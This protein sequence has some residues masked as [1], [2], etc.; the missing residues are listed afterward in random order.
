MRLRLFVSALMLGSTEAHATRVTG[1]DVLAHW[2][3]T[4]IERL[5]GEQASLAGQD[6]IRQ[7]LKEP[8]SPY[9]DVVLQPDFTNGI[10][11]SATIDAFADRGLTSVDALAA[12][13]WDLGMTRARPGIDITARKGFR[14][15]Y[16][17]A[18]ASKAD[19][20]ADIFWHMLDLTGFRHSTKAAVYAVGM[21]ILRSQAIAV[22]SEQWI[23][24]GIDASVFARVM[25]AQHMD[26]LSHYDLEYLS[27]LVQYRLLHW[28]AGKA[29]SAGHRSLPVAYRVARAAAAY[30]DAQGYIGS[31][32]CTRD[33]SPSLRSAGSG[34]HGDDRPLC[35]TARG[36]RPRGTCLVPGGILPPG[37][38][39][40]RSP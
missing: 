40:A 24:T 25:G 12:L 23:A 13:R 34:G 28:R 9:S 5:G 33:G 8:T 27:A 37:D 35:F 10:D 11:W 1:T 30:R 21:Q 18:S 19:V 16:V 38:V 32:P 2:Q 31:A 17:S 20:D 7:M 15:A 26:Q 36:H 6:I 3:R 29:G 14:D 22:P 39:R 4:R